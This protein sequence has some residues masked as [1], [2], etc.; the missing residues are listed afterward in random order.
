MDR[1]LPPEAVESYLSAPKTMG[2]EAAPSKLAARVVR[3]GGRPAGHDRAWSGLLTTCLGPDSGGNHRTTHCQLQAHKTPNPKRRRKSLKTQ[4]EA[5]M[6]VF[7]FIEGW[8][9]PHRRHS[10]LDYRSPIYYKRS[11]SAETG[12]RSPT[13]PTESG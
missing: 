7:D 10:A 8:Y 9:N 1:G 2:G 5:R 12:Y 4:A 6:A 3:Q 13:P 11:H